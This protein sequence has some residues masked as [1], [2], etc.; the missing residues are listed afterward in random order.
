MQ[1]TIDIEATY[2]YSTSE[3]DGSKATVTIEISNEIAT[4]IR[5]LFHSAKSDDEGRLYIDKED[6]LSAI[7]AGHVELQPLHD[8][9]TEQFYRI[10][11][12]HWLFNSDIKEMD[13]T[14]EPAF[15]DDVKWGLYS[16]KLD[17]ECRVDFDTPNLSFASCRKNYLEW[18]RTHRDD[19]PFI[20]NRL[21]VDLDARSENDFDYFIYAF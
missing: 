10:D 4:T 9:L 3:W 19:Y 20:A 14:L 7:N 13:E 15:Y 8:S 6:V 11:D 5:Q 12:E 2:G 21:G 1:I 18:V 16:P 17:N